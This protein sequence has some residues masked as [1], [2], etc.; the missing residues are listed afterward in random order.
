MNTKNRKIYVVGPQKHYANWMEGKLVDSMYKADL[1]VFTGGEDVNPALY[2]EKPNKYTSFNKERDEFEIRQFELCRDLNKPIIGICR[3]SQL[4][5]VLSGGKLVQDQN[6]PQ[7][8]HKIETY[9]GKNIIVSS[10]HHQAQYPYLMDKS[11]YK[12]IGWSKGVA[13]F[14]HDAYGKELELPEGKEVEICYYP[15]INA[16]GIQ[17]HPEMIMDYIQCPEV[18]ESIQYCRGL[19]NKLLSSQL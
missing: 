2:G 7:F 17:G 16:L 13:N 3:G 1:V 8:L 14:H 12:L 4:L 18:A 9:D 15:K 6:N 19:L 11:N 5:C 10:T